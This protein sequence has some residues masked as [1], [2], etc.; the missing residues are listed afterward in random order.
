ML[1][2]SLPADKPKIV[3]RDF[4][5]KIEKERYKPRIGSE[6]LHEESNDIRSIFLTYTY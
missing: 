5:A 6:S 3:I 4:N 1:Y 2:D